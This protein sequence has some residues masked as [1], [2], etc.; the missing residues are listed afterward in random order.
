MERARQVSEVWLQ[1]HPRDG[2]ARG[3]ASTVYNALGR[4]GEAANQIEAACNFDPGF[5]IPHY[6]LINQYL[7]LNRFK[8]AAR[9]A[10]EAE[11]RYPKSPMLCVNLYKL[12]FLQNDSARR[13]GQL[14]WAGGKPGIEDVLLAYESDTL[15]YSG[16]LRR[17][18]Q[19]SQAAIDSAQR[20]GK[21]ETAARYKAEAGLRES[22][23]GNSYE[24]VRDSQAALAMS[25]ARDVQYAVVLSLAL[26]GV[27]AV[28]TQ[29]ERLVRDLA[30]RFSQDTVVQF[31]YLPALSAALGLSRSEAGKANEFLQPIRPIDIATTGWHGEFLQLSLYPIYVRG[32]SYLAAHRGQEAAAEFQKILDH[33]GIVFNEPIGALAYVGLARAYALA[34]D[35]NRSRAQYDE[36]FALWKDADPDVPIFRQ[37]KAEY[38]KVALNGTNRSHP[39]LNS[40][41]LHS[42]I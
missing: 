5:G 40:K 38:T 2:P 42:G 26:S 23:L 12:A 14:A 1:R 9:T 6:I 19:L 24:G 30:D 27:A 22:L 36:F 4:Y 11:A 20:A 34:G 29:C 16:R 10:E 3:R 25:S 17:A 15:A 8:D 39:T 18:R 21:I 35:K 41:L 37:V 33:S 7:F 28:R 31:S 32:Q 13:A